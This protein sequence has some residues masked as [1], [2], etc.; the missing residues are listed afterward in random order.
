M[1]LLEGYNSADTCGISYDD[2]KGGCF[3]ELSD[4]S[5]CLGAKLPYLIQSTRT[6]HLRVVLNFDKD[7]GGKSELG[8]GQYMLLE[9][10]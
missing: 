8:A 2:Y 10:F 6:G 1:E 7:I 9:M 5:T 4:T 3:I